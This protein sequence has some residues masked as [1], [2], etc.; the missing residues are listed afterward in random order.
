MKKYC[1]ISLLVF[2]AFTSCTHE[3][4]VMEETYPNGSPKRECVYKGKDTSHELI[5]ETTWYPNKKIQMSGEFK[6][7]KRDGKWIYYYKN[8]NV[9]SEGFF[10]DGKSDGKRTTHYE[11]GKIFYEGYYQEDRRV[12]V[13]KFY[14]EKGTLVKSVDYNKELNKVQKPSY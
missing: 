1:L 6:E 14:D 12:G 5:R 11:N 10:K 9:W 13:W 3:T 4:K 7:K 8:G 2:F